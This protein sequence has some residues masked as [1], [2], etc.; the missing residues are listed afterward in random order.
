VISQV[1]NEVAKVTFIVVSEFLSSLSE[2]VDETKS[3]VDSKED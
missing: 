1:A 3:A 2:S